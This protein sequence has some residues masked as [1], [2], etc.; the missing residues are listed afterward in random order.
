[1]NVT[2]DVEGEVGGGNSGDSKA[3]WFIDDLGLLTRQRYTLPSSE[4]LGLLAPACAS[5]VPDRSRRH[6]LSS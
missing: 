4:G 3:D 1:M 2:M 6:T 5:G